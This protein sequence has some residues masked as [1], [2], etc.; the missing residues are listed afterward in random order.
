MIEY[1]EYFL[2]LFAFSNLVFLVLVSD[3]VP[4]FPIV[5]LI[6]ALLHSA[7]PMGRF[8]EKVCE[9]NYIFYN[10]SFLL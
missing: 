4:I 8:N 1:L 9:V 7:L 6:V 5:G 2:I 10:L 3:E